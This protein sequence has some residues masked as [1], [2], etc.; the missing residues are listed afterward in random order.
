MLLEKRA[1]D[2][3]LDGSVT[4]LVRRW[5]RPQVVA[6]RVYRTAAGLI[7]V[8]E[9]REVEPAA[10]TDAD[11]VP[12][13]YG[14]AAELRADLRGTEGDPVYVLRV[15]PADGPDPRTVLASTAE[16]TDAEVAELDR[17]LDRLDRASPS[18]PWTASVLAAIRAEPGRRAGDLAAA[19]GREMLP[20]KADVRKL[21]AL[22]LTL[23]LPVGYRLSPRGE[24]YLRATTR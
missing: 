15:R 5:K 21:K 22:G 17:R 18:G 12:A 3:I 13:G 23:S 9:V 16:L 20:Y 8:D 6:G 24:A 14:S 7:A 2:G 11:A 4:V 10:L 19:A 1:R